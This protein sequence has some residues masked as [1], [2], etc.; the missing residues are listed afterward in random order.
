[1]DAQRF[2]HDDD[3]RN[4][5]AS[6]WSSSFSAFGLRRGRDKTVNAG[7]QPGA[8]AC[9]VDTHLFAFMDLPR[10]RGRERRRGRERLWKRRRGIKLHDCGYRPSQSDRSIGVSIATTRA[11]VSVPGSCLLASF[12]NRPRRRRRPRSRP[13]V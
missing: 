6:S 7:R 2:K 1:M 13:L 11:S 5:H 4:W 10:G 8:Q 3:V 9:T 12:P